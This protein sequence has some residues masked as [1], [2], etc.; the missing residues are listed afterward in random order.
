VSD[1]SYPVTVAVRQPDGSVQHVR[2]GTAVRA[3]D[4]FR[5]TLGDL[6]IG[7]VADAPGA[8]SGF[9]LASPAAAPRRAAPS[10]DGGGGAGGMVFPPYGRSKGAPIAGA[11]QQDLEFYA[12][13]CH[14]TLN[15]P[16]KSRWH[17]KERQLLAAIEAELARQGVS[18]GTGGTGGGAPAGG[19]GGW[20]GGGGGGGGSGE[21]GAA[22]KRF[23]DDRPPPSDEDIPF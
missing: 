20:G 22:S 21:F 6:S 16:A 18:G 12:N 5:L 14:R 9:A 3:G 11:S 13:G 1:S 2:V 10:F 19:G 17:D 8:S 15:D 4:G 7:G 23:E